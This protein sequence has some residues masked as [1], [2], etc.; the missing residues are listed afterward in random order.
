MSGLEIQVERPA[1]RCPYC[2]DEIALG[3]EPAT[4]PFC[5]AA[6]HTECVLEHGACAACGRAHPRLNPATAAV[7]APPAPSATPSGEWPPPVNAPRPGD[8]LYR[9]EEGIE[10]RGEFY[11]RQIVGS[12]NYRTGGDLVDFAHGWLNYQIEHHLWPDMSMLSYRR[13]APRVREICERHG[14]PYVQGSVWTRLGK[15]VDVAV[16]DSSMP[17]WESEP[18]RV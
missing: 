3:V 15:L 9:F 13:A 7:P 18:A 12:T 16:G 2:H 5:H 17:Y 4:C 10:G 6:H 11:L 1:S 8:D 14:V